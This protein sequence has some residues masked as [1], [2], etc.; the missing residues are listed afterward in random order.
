MLP[1]LIESQ[2]AL[3]IAGRSLLLHGDWHSRWARLRSQAG[4]CSYRPACRPI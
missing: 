2:C 3:V 4:A 1:G